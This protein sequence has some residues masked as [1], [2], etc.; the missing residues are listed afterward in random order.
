MSAWDRQQREEKAEGTG[1]GHAYG[2]E[3]KKEVENRF[4]EPTEPEKKC[5]I[6]ATAGSV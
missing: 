2:Q 1:R 5:C 3:S 4:R 6:I